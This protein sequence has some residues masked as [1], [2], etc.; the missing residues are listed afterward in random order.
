MKEK[1]KEQENSQNKK[2]VRC[3]GIPVKLISAVLFLCLSV[4]AISLY[5]YDRYRA[6][7][8][9]S[10]DLDGYISEQKERFIAGEITEE[11]LTENMNRLKEAVDRIPGNTVVLTADVV[12][13]NAEIITP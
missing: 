2:Q 12:V 5:L 1:Q 3:S 13:K 6:T 9:V 10:V 11:K 7:R 8:I 4:S